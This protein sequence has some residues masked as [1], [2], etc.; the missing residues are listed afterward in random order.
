[1]RI[2]RPCAV[3]FQG[4]YI[5]D[6]YVMRRAAALARTAGFVDVQVRSH[7]YVQVDDPVYMRSIADR[8]ADALVAAGTL[9]TDGAAARKAEVRRRVDE[10]G[11]FGHIAYMSLIARKS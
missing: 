10:G 5:N 8:G 6:P 7:G 4:T 11:F 2:S 9:D 1:M 3:A